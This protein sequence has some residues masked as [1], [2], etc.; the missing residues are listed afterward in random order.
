MT[1]RRYALGLW[2][3]ATFACGPRPISSTDASQETST[4]STSTGASDDASDAEETDDAETDTSDAPS[5][6]CESVLVR[7][8][9]VSAVGRSE[10]VVL[11]LL[12]E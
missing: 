1:P 4:G 5:D 2:L 12:N 8:K 7:G 9:V 3:C 11:D 6:G 10:T